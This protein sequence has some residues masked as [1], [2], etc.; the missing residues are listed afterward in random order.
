M[1]LPGVGKGGAEIIRG[2]AVVG[3]FRETTA[4]STTAMVQGPDMVTQPPS[5]GHRA[6]DVVGLIISAETME[7]Q[8]QYLGFTRVVP[9]RQLI[10]I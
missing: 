7:N 3:P 6:A 4:F 8:H 2:T 9:T 10:A 1:P 5:Q